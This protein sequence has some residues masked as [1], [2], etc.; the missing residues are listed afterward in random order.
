MKDVDN[1]NMVA[2]LNRTRAN[3]DSI[4]IDLSK[5]PVVK[6][7]DNPNLKKLDCD[8]SCS[9]FKRNKA[10]AEA[11]EIDQP[12]LK[13]SSLFGE[14]PLRLLKE[15]TLQDYKF[16]AATYNSLVRFVRSAKDS[17]KRFIFMQFPPSNKLRREVIHELAHHFHCT[18]ESREEE[19]FRHVV[20]RAY[21]NKSV[22]PEFNIE[23]LLP[24]TD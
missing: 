9:L 23:Q 14:D 20:V 19:P 2:M 6:Q 21:K 11:L 24:V 3:E 8:D 1:R 7:S 13:P 18:S 4:M 16:V 12:D 22:V 17:D 10:L 5:K 15:A